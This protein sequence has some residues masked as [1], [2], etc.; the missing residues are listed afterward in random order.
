MGAPFPHL[1][2]F[3]ASGAAPLPIQAR[4]TDDDE[5]PVAGAIISLLILDAMMGDPGRGYT[6]SDCSSPSS[7]Y[8]SAFD[9]SGFDSGSSL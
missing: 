1:N 3:T 9:S 8:G 5:F 2:P 7:D 6:P 4:K